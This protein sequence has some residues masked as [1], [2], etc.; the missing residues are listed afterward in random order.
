MGLEN[1]RNNH[2]TGIKI[3]DGNVGGASKSKL[4]F[5]ISPAYTLSACFVC[6]SLKTKYMYDI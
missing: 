4:D 2:S 6:V 5:S 3:G 1:I